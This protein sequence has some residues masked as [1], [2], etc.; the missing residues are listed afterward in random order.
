VGYDDSQIYAASET[1]MGEGGR[2]G[3]ERLTR[4]RGR[5]YPNFRMLGYGEDSIKGGYSGRR[6]CSQNGFFCLAQVSG[7]YYFHSCLSSRATGLGIPEDYGHVC[8]S[9]SLTRRREQVRRRRHADMRRTLNARNRTLETSDHG[10]GPRFE[11]IRNALA[12]GEAGRA[13]KRAAKRLQAA[14]GELL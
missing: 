10:I 8:P 9:S 1:L 2:G 14:W 4:C 13:P 5:Q 11:R 3:W 7:D 12:G 6:K